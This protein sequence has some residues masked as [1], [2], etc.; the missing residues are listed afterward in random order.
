MPVVDARGDCDLR[1]LRRSDAPRI[2]DVLHEASDLWKT[3]SPYWRAQSEADVLEMCDRRFVPGR[4]DRMDLGIYL[5]TGDVIGQ[6]S[7]HAIDWRNRVGRLGIAVWKRNDRRNGHGS[8]AL[9]KIVELSFDELDLFRLEALVLCDNEASLALFEKCGFRVEG[10]LR[11]R[12][13]RRGRRI[14]IT[15]LARLRDE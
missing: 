11:R 13:L 9:R 4:S 8:T 2:L 10:T 14:D 7:V 3:G 15:V 12:Y 5:P 1:P 6:C